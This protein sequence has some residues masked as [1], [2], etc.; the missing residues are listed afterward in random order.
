MKLEG[1]GTKEKDME[2][3]ERFQELG[4]PFH[5]QRETRQLDISQHPLHPQD[6]GQFKSSNMGTVHINAINLKL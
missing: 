3:E 4:K 6:R 1:K 5:V 2:T